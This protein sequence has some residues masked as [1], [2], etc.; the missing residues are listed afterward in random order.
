MTPEEMVDRATLVFVGVVQ[1]HKLINWPWS[2]GGEGW[3][4]LVRRVTVET[5]ARGSESRRE[6]DVYEYFGIGGAGGNWNSTRDGERYLFLVR[7]EGAR[8]H[9]VR[10]WWRS[11]FHVA[12]GYHGRFPLSASAPLWERFALLNLWPGPD[13]SPR[14]V[15]PMGHHGALGIGL[16]RRARILRGFLRHPDN[17]LRHPACEALI[18]THQLADGCYFQ[19]LEERREGTG[20][21]YNAVV[22][23]ERWED[24]RRLEADGVA[25]AMRLLQE[26]DHDWSYDQLRLLTTISNP[27][28]RRRICDLFRRRIPRETDH[29]CP[30]NPS[31]PAS[32]VTADG[33]VLLRP[34][35]APDWPAAARLTTPRNP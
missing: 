8:Y 27:E 13:W 19:L 24:N 15:D 20:L 28:V 33:E 32:Y 3:G 16:W 22:L 21:I 29:G 1:S 11:I 4:M 34:E 5:V 30:P 12:S 26:T 2:P 10:D 31:A 23:R 17:R 7:K 18:V 6:I 14:L 25:F 35:E 9:V